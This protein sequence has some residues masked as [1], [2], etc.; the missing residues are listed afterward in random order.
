M[1]NYTLYIII[2]LIFLASVTAIMLRETTPAAE[3]P[4]MIGGERDNYGCLG[5]AG[6][7]YDETIGACVRSF[8]LTPDIAEAAQI[9]V[10]HVGAGYALTV[11]SFTAYEEPGVYDIFL[12][13]GIERTPQI[14]H[15]RGGVVVDTPPRE[16][17]PAPA[18]L[19]EGKGG[20][21][22]QNQNSTGE[23]GGNSSR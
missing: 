22:R 10:A 23:S 20:N 4:T 18:V 19:E 11:V 13:R 6:Y 9:A 3:A 14:V 15:I 8:E 21:E 17:L 5:P 1:K 12:E 7:A 16:P 2:T